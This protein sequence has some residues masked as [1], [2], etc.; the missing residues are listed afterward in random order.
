MKRTGCNSFV[1]GTLVLMADGS[2]KPIDQIQV[3]ELVL[4]SDPQTGQTGSRLVLGVIAGS[5]V[6]S[7]V[8]ITTAAGDGGGITTG[9]VVATDGHPFWVP[10]LSQ[11]IQ[12]TDLH[13]GM[14]L[15]TSAGTYV[16]VTVVTKWTAKQYAH[17]LAVAALHTYYVIEGGQAVLVHNAPK[18]RDPSGRF[19][20]GAGGENEDTANGRR[21]HESYRNALGPDYDYD[22]P[23]KS[24]R[25]PDAID[26][27]NRIV[28]ELKSDAPSNDARGRRQLQRYVDELEQATGQKWTGYLDRYKSC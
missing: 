16:Q 28:R 26:R 9:T 12:A 24:G 11:W 22:Q 17:N 4:A 27:K 15:R 1:A 25:R 8:E 7:L 5:G 2:H 20:S 18:P 21:V 13:P 19:T 14:L 6:K 3:G 10:N 23:L